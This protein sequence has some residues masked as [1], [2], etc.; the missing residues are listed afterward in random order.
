MLA[1]ASRPQRVGNRPALTD[2]TVMRS[3][4][5]ATWES[6]TRRVAGLS[7]A[8]QW[9]DEGNGF[10][11]LILAHVMLSVPD[12]HIQPASRMRRSDHDG[13]GRFR[14][15]R[16][17]RERRRHHRDKFMCDARSRELRSS[18]S[19]DSSRRAAG[20]HQTAWR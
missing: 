6:G 7:Q 14:G 12:G 3:G 1:Q 8:T 11:D 19:R 5:P 15:S 16:D 18:R 20:H 17:G 13:R 2:V 9:P 4:R 10:I